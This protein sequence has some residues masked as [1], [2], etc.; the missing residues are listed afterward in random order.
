MRRCQQKRQPLDGPATCHPV[1]PRSREDGID[2]IH[3]GERPPKCSSFRSGRTAA[4]PWGRSTT[5]RSWRLSRAGAQFTLSK[6]RTLRNS[7]PAALVPSVTEMNVFPSAKI[8]RM[9][10]LPGT[11][12]VY[13]VNSTVFSSIT[14]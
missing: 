13:G 7:T 3:F 12:S 10:G 8:W 2:G 1:G 5:G 4:F 11:P 6:T 14:R 9:L